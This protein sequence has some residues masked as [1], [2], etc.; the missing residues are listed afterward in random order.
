[1]AV[2]LQKKVRERRIGMRPR[3]FVGSSVAQRHAL[4]ECFAIAFYA[5]CNQSLHSP[6]AVC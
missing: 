6:Y 2:L 1:M 4:C 5:V 3:S